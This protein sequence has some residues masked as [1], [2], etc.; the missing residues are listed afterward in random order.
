MR[1]IRTYEAYERY[2]KWPIINVLDLLFK[3]AGYNTSLSY[4][5]IQI[6]LDI[7]YFIDVSSVDEN[8]EIYV[9]KSSQFFDDLVPIF[10][11]KLESISTVSEYKWAITWKIK[12]ENVNRAIEIFQDS[13]LREEIQFYAA[14]NKYNL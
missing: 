14:V 5:G 13:S 9:Q 6:H 4:K 1:Y 10:K 11:N 8:I 12:K 2:N 3:T 7:T